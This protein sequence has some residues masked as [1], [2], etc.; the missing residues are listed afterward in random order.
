M[1]ERLTS[2]ID[3]KI[4]IFQN[5]SFELLRVLLQNVYHRTRAF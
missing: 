2:D 4:R 3:I 1:L 5:C